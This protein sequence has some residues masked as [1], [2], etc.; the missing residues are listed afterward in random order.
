LRLTCFCTVADNRSILRIGSLLDK[1]I[2]NDGNPAIRKVDAV[3]GTPCAVDDPVVF[4]HCN[5]SPAFDL[6][7]NY[8]VVDIGV[9]DREL[10]N[11]ANIDVVRLP[12]AVG[13]V[14]KLAVVDCNGAFGLGRAEDPVLALRG[15]GQ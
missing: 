4:D 15:D 13:I 1:I 10:G 11:L 12:I 14:G 9:G 2:L 5:C 6:V 7:T 8:G 3:A